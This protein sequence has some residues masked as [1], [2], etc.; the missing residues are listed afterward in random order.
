MS[1]PPSDL[2]I[3]K[4]RVRVELCLHQGVVLRTEVFVTEHDGRP[5]RRQD[6]HDLF[7]Q[8][9]AFLPARALDEESWMVVSRDA[10]LWVRLVDEPPR[11]EEPVE[12]EELFDVQRAV[13]VE[14]VSGPA[15]IGDLL[16]SPPPGHARVADFLNE[17]GRF[18]PLWTDAGEVLVSKAHVVR[19]FETASRM[20]S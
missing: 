15:L 14:L 17:T 18:F 20:G 3:P 12:A 2:R 7:E 4:H 5:W 9:S 16:Y 1:P 11:D 10:L 13:R 6:V 8:T 19:V